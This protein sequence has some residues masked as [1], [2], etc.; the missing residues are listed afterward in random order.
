MRYR[1]DFGPFIL[2]VD[3]LPGRSSSATGTKMDREI[4]LWSY[5]LRR[6]FSGTAMEVMQAFRVALEDRG[7]LT[8]SLRNAYERQFREMIDRL[9]ED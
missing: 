3:V 9:F 7:I 2:F 6:R 5:T 8:R 1:F 4:E